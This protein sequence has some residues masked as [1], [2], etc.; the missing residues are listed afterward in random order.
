MMRKKLPAG[1]AV[2]AQTSDEKTATGAHPPWQR[3]HGRA[4]G[5]LARMPAPS[6]WAA[7]TSSPRSARRCAPRSKSPRSPPKSRRACAPRRPARG[8]SRRR[9]RL[10]PGRCR[11]PGSR[12]S[13]APTAAIFVRLSSDRGVQEPFVD[14]ILEIT[15][16]TGR[17]VRDYTLLFDPPACAQRAPPGRGRGRRQRRR[18]A[19]DAACRRAAAPAVPRRSADCRRGSAAR[20]A[21]ATDRPR[22]KPAPATA[23]RSRC[24]TGRH[25]CQDRRGAQ[26][27]R[28]SRSTRCWSRC[29]APIPTPS[30]ATT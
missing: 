4:A 6:A 27:G 25:R 5:C 21:A 16:A 7:S 3:R 2:G 28:A 12:F 18:P 15:W 1:R 22:A 20:R 14:V 19:A 8:V 26:A 23:S 29:S 10:Q 17:L 13:A 30:S 11:A 9:R 24:K